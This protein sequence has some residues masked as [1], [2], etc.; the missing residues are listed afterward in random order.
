MINLLPTSLRKDIS[1]ARRN[2]TLLHWNIILVGI[3]LLFGLVVA[4]G[5]V[6]IGHGIKNYENQV[7][8]AQE[9][10]KLQQIDTTQAKVQSIS[11]N[12]K[13]IDQVLSKQVLFSKLLQELGTLMPPG[14]VLERLELTGETSGAID[15]TVMARNFTS[16]T[17]VPI[18]FADPSNKLFEK[19]DTLSVSCSGTP[20]GSTELNTQY[21]CRVT[22]RVLFKKPNPFL[23]TNQTES[24]K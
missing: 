24:K 14:A 4:G 9:D 8:T 13:L 3:L 22:I 18:N 10:L 5:Y 1:Y 2:R 12:V 21:P 16:A 6:Y 17:Q 7:K 15:L 11:D 19:V 20:T 23:L